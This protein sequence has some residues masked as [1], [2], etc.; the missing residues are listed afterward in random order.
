MLLL[1]LESLVIETFSFAVIFATI[2]FVL[3][4][5]SIVT[6]FWTLILV[7]I[8]THIIIIF[9]SYDDTKEC[10]RELQDVILHIIVLY[11]YSNRN[12]S[13][14]HWLHIP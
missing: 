5:F 13:G 10:R 14:E 3:S 8:S 6:L 9:L 4:I 11:L 7:K 2:V 12:C 1:V